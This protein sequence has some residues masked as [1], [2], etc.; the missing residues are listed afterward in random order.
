[1]RWYVTGEHPNYDKQDGRHYKR[2]R[3]VSTHAE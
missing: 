1:M 3:I 2:K